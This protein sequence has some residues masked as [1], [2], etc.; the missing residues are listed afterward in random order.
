MKHRVYG[1]DQAGD[2]II[3][4]DVTSLSDEEFMDIAEKQGHVWTL[5]G[6]EKAFNHEGISETWIIRIIKIEN[7]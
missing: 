4:T 1:I 3:N 5:N 6:F 7:K 2:D